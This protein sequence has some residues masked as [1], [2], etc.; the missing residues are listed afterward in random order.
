MI[1]K[2]ADEKGMQVVEQRLQSSFDQL[3]EE[4]DPNFHY[5]AK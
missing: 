3:D 4:I 5:E 1:L 2:K